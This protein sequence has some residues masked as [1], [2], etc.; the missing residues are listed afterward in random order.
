MKNDLA[1]RI[2]NILVG[3]FIVAIVLL[4]MMYRVIMR[5]VIPPAFKRSRY[6]Y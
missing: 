1:H 2:T 6:K 5:G 4:Y 3:S